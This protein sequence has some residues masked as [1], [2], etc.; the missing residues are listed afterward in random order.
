MNF[1][2]VYSN[3]ISWQKIYS[4]LLR[5][6]LVQESS[7]LGSFLYI[8]WIIYRIAHILEKYSGRGL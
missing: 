6:I 4:M 5:G 2:D 3:K 1:I 7:E 8:L